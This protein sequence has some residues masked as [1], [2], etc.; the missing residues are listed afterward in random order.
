VLASGEYVGKVGAVQDV[1]QRGE[2][3]HPDMGAI[4]VRNESIKLGI[5]TRQK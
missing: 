2:Y 1:L 3:A 5:R 4:L